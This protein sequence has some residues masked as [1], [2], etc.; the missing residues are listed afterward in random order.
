MVQSRSLAILVG[1]ALAAA[2][3]AGQQVT[4]RQMDSLP[5]EVR[6]QQPASAAPPVQQA[7]AAGTYMNVSFV[8]LTDFGWSTEPNVESL[9]VGDHDPH[10]RGFS[11]PNA[12]LALDG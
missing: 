11:I 1:T 10:V 12:E 4:R 7:R 2:P 5:A 3:A 9:Q 8:G 6:A